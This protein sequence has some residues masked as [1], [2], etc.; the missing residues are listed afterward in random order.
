[1]VTLVQTVGV[2]FAALAVVLG[3]F[4]VNKYSEVRTQLGEIKDAA[5]S[6]KEA[7]KKVG[8]TSDKLNDKFNERIDQVE[9]LFVGIQTQK[10]VMDE[11]KRSSE[12][13]KEAEAAIKDTLALYELAVKHKNDRIKSYFAACLTIIYI[14]MENWDE[15][16]RFGQISI[17]CNPKSWGDRSF[18]MACIYARKFNHGSEQVDRHHVRRWLTS[19]FERNGADNVEI[20]EVDDALEDDDLKLNP[21]IAADIQEMKQTY[22]AKRGKGGA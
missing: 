22:Q 6:A 19:Y 12:K 7:S 3:Y 11:L 16:I 4:G 20:A 9:R 15:A 1:M 17:D 13:K 8:E 21:T 10:M 18:N 5:K 14:Q 2:V